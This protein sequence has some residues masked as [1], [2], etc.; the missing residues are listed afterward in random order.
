MKTFTS[1][2][3]IIL[4]SF[5][6]SNCEKKCEFGEIEGDVAFYLLDSFETIGE[7]CK[8]DDSSVALQNEALINYDQ[9]LSYDSE[10]FT[11]AVNDEV[12]ELMDESYPVHGTAFGVVAD[13]ALIYTGYFWPS[14]SSLSC[15]WYTIDP[16]FV[17]INNNM[18]VYMGYPGEHP[19][20][21][22]PD[23][24]NDERIICIFERDGKLID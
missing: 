9:L 1:L 14:Y 10:N 21:I 13:G 17:K 6:L 5:G 15:N 20:L 8:I 12:L 11:F 2:L 3:I 7:G 23:K 16:I 24:R 19:D 18:R 22:D 4:I